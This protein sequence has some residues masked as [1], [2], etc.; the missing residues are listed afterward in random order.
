M[1][2]TQ[3]IR[4]LGVRQSRVPLLK[5]GDW[6]A[7]RNE[8]SP[9]EVMT[10]SGGEA[11]SHRDVKQWLSLCSQLRLLQVHCFSRCSALSHQCLLLTW[12]VPRLEHPSRLLFLSFKNLS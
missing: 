12:M 5:E 6:T 7:I 4:R 3:S 10:D 1:K 2:G 9:G 11:T 8:V